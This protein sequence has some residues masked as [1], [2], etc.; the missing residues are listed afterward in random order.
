MLFL[1]TLIALYSNCFHV[2]R[3]E[4]QLKQCATSCWPYGGTMGPGSQKLQAILPF[5]VKSSNLEYCFIEN[6]DGVH[7][8]L[9]VPSR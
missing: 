9:L 6:K 7:Y 1:I 8:F 5:N 2:G 3:K 4:K